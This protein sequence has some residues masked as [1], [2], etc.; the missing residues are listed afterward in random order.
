MLASKLL[1]HLKLWDCSQDKCSLPKAGLMKGRDRKWLWEPPNIQKRPRKSGTEE[2][3]GS[4]G[5]FQL[6]PLVLA[7]RLAFVGG[8][9]HGSRKALGTQMLVFSIGNTFFLGCLEL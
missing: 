3:R 7:L 8:Y 6:V 5:P 9:S 1:Q 4:R 2:H